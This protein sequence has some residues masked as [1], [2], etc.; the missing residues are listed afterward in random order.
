MIGIQRLSARVPLNDELPHGYLELAP[1]LRELTFPD[2]NLAACHDCAMKY[3]RPGQLT[4]SAEARCCTYQPTLRNFLIGRI[5]HSGGEGAARVLQRLQDLDG[6]EPHLLSPPPDASRRYDE[7]AQRAFGSDPTLTC[8]FWQEGPQGCTIYGARNAVCRTWFCKLQ[9]GARAS[10][11]WGTLKM[12]LIHLERLLADHCVQTGDPPGEGATAT[13]WVAWYEWCADTVEQ[14]DEPTVEGLRDQKLTALL[15]ALQ[16]TVTAR[17]APIPDVVIPQVRDWV[18][19]DE[20]VAMTSWSIYDRV[21]VPGWIFHLLSKL[22][23]ETAWREAVRAVEAER[24]HPVGEDLVLM[25]W[26]RGILGHPVDWSSI[27]VNP[28]V[29]KIFRHGPDPSP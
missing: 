10:A 23:G 6:V 1:I 16:A 24:G 2:E 7:R 12:V 11:V 21:I 29:T 9:Q 26:R 14:L 17:D 4:F 15:E 5:L 18:V 13:D 25:L 19:L 28:D 20:H 22:D 3:T 27:Q 8:S